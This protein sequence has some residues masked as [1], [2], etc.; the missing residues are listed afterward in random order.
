MTMGDNVGIAGR[1]NAKPM[2]ILPPEE[3]KYALAYG[4]PWLI[5]LGETFDA[6]NDTISMNLT[7][8]NTNNT[9]LELVTD[10]TAFSYL[11]IE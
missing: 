8:T 11:S 5:D 7:C 2:F 4:E 3:E 10:E 9:F 6:D 1:I